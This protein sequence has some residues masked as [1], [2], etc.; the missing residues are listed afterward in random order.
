MMVMLM[1]RTIMT[2]T[3]KISQVDPNGNEDGDAN[4]DDDK[5]EH[6]EDDE[7][8]IDEEDAEDVGRMKMSCG[9]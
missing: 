8:Y 3:I 2:M 4:E 1:M 9:C 5:A 6:E 7:N